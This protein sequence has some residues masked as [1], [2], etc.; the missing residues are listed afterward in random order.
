MKDLKYLVAYVL[1]MSA[2]LALS[3]KGPW[4]WATVVLGFGIIPVLE[5]WMPKSTENI[6]PENEEPRSRRLLFDAMLYLNL[7]ILF[8]IVFWF[9]YTV[10]FQTLTVSELLGLTLGT[11]IVVGSVG[12]NVA[13]ELGHRVSGYEQAISKWML[14]PALYQ[15]FFI[16]HNRGHHKNVATDLDPA[17]AR[18]GEWLF[19]FWP[20]SMAGGWLGAWRL[21]R[22]RLEKNSQPLWGTHNE[23]VR[24]QAWQTAWLAG[25]M[26]ILGWKALAGAVAIAL[27]GVLLLETINYVEHYGLRRKMLPSGRPE[28]VAPTHSWNSDHEMG[29]IFLYELT[30]HSDHHYKATRKFQILRHLDDS[31]QLPFG[32]PTSV[33]LALV[34]PLWFR[35]M[36]GRVPAST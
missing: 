10:Q 22:E 6:P 33:L 36:N 28:P 18:K 17:S 7:P 29:R 35:V 19:A 27:V 5:T 15:H 11:G 34:P 12:I 16:E 1:P 2:V 23:M 3:W 14:L 24:F 21:E 25:I 4:A 8:G 32:Y 9:L 20:R 26:F 31:P 30:R 13:H